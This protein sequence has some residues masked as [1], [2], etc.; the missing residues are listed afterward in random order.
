MTNDHNVKMLSDELHDLADDITHSSSAARD[1]ARRGIARHTRNRRTAI[2]SA[3]AVVVIAATAV[4]AVDRGPG[5]ARPP[6][7]TTRVVTATTE[8]P[9]T[10]PTTTVPAGAPAPGSP[11]LSRVPPIA[12][13]AAMSPIYARTFPWGTGPDQV[14]Y[15]APHGEGVSGG[16]VT[17]TAD[18]AGNIVMLDHSSGRLVRLRNGAGSADPIGVTPAVTAAVFDAQGRVIVATVSD[19]AVFGP[20]GQPEGTWTAMSK[21]GAAITSLE[22]AGRRVYSVDRN[23]TRTVLLRDDGSGYVAVRDAAPETASI[24]V[25]LGAVDLRMTVTNGTEYELQKTATLNEVRA[26]KLLSDG[27]LVF[28]LGFEQHGLTNP[29]APLTY[30][31]GRIDRQGHARYQTV[32]VP[33][34]YLLSPGFVINDDG[35]AVMGSTTA[36]GATVTYYPFN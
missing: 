22:V 34:G 17:F 29:D 14:A 4:V 18:A 30:V 5:A 21:A 10:A 13:L 28:V 20:Q 35:L 31:V 36:G 11:V 16:P 25:T 15:S 1:R 32:A 12:D 7:G 3:A 24:T 33:T 8:P 6:T 2:G 26:V 9:V 27:S 19:L 23:R